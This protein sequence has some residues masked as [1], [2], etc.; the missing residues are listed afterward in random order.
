VLGDTCITLLLSRKGHP[1][2]R[3]LKNTGGYRCQN[4]GGGGGRFLH[5]SQTRCTRHGTVPRWGYNN[6]M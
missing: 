4:A 6:N 1:D 2:S 3:D 5:N